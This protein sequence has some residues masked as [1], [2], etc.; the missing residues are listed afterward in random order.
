MSS[1]TRPCVGGVREPGLEKPAA[2]RW[3]TPGI[4]KGFGKAR[5]RMQ[6]TQLRRRQHGLA[7]SDGNTLSGISDGIGKQA[8]Q[9]H[10]AV[11]CLP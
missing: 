3:R 9:R 11:Q 2:R 1:E 5:L 7:G 8:R 4:E 10:A 6:F